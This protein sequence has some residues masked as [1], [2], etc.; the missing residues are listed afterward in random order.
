MITWWLWLLSFTCKFLGFSFISWTMRWIITLVPEAL[1]F[2]SVRKTTALCFPSLCS[3]THTTSDTRCV[4]FPYKWFCDTSWGPTVQFG[5]DTINP[6]LATSS[7]R[8]RAHS[9]K[10][11]SHFSCQWQVGSPQVT[12]NF[13]PTWL[14]IRGSHDLFLRFSHLLEWLTEHKK[15]MY[16]LDYQFIIRGYNSAT[17][18]MEEMHRG[19]YGGG[20]PRGS[21]SGSGSSMP[22]LDKPPSQHLHV[23]TNA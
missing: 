17:G 12:H 23:V 4:G 14:Q 5:S 16:L 22:S 10:T 15:T 21:G 3:A 18:Q 11:T 20:D 8:L 19:R 6:E 2:P 9:H 7:H 13:C 1:E